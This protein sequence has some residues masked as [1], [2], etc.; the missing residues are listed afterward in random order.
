MSRSRS[1]L[2]LVLLLAASCSDVGPS[3]SGS[4]YL[5]FAFA[6]INDVRVAFDPAV[7]ASERLSAFPRLSG[8]TYTCPFDSTTA[9][10]TCATISS[11]DSDS[12]RETLARAYQLIDTSGTALDAYEPGAMTV[13]RVIQDHSFSGHASNVPE[14]SAAY[15]GSAHSD[16]AL[17]GLHTGPRVVNGSGNVAIVLGDSSNATHA[18]ATFSLTNVAVPERPAGSA[19][20]DWPKSGVVRYDV[21]TSGAGVASDS[22]S[23]RLTFTGGNQATYTRT[24]AAITT[25][26]SCYWVRSSTGPGSG[27]CLLSP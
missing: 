4:L 13:V 8:P 1:L 21:V 20:P 16:V 11:P 18:S 17:S 10:F 24:R 23:V 7:W 2:S 5:T 3:D 26:G 27:S 14:E 6:D 22:V 9:L 15:E 25:R 19:Y 12:D